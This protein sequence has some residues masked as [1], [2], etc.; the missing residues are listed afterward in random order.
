M[1]YESEKVEQSSLNGLNSFRTC[2]IALVEYAK[3]SA[4]F[5]FSVSFGVNSHY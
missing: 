3:V 4:F 1:F 5:L 2:L